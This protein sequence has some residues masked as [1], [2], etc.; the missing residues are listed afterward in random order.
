M[1]DA[2]W[3]AARGDYSEDETDYFKERVGRILENEARPTPN[4]EWQARMQAWTEL[5]TRFKKP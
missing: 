2:E 3:L 5:K 4:R 1:T